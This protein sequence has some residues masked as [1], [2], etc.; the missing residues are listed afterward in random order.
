MNS[1]Q[2]GAGGITVAPFQAGNHM[3]VRRWCI[4]GGVVIGTKPTCS[5]FFNDALGWTS[6]FSAKEILCMDTG[7]KCFPAP[8]QLLFGRRKKSYMDTHSEMCTEA[9][10]IA[11]GVCSF[12]CRLQSSFISEVRARDALS[13][14]IHQWIEKCTWRFGFGAWVRLELRLCINPTDPGQWIRQERF[15]SPSASTP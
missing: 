11:G 5:V 9:A 14:N 12:T 6:A 4:Q 3:A 15:G 10:D 13:P 8:C 7:P 2:K 1:R